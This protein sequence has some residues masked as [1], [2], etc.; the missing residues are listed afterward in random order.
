MFYRNC[1]NLTN[2]NSIDI[3]IIIQFSNNDKQRNSKTI[4]FHSKSDGTS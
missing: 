1:Q 3:V 2:Q 4:R